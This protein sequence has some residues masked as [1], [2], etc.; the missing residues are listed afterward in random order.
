MFN[1]TDKFKT[2]KAD[3]S[4]IFIVMIW[5]TTFPLMKITLGNIKPFYFISLRFITA[6]IV[7]TLILNKRILK[8]NFKTFKIGVFLGLLLFSGFAFQIYGLQFTTASKSGFITGLSVLIVPILSIFILKEIPSLYAWVG[9]FLALIGIYLLTG[10]T[11]M[12]FN[13]GDLLTFFCAVSIALQIVFLSKYIKKEDPLIITWLQISTVMVVGTIL[14]FFESSSGQ[15]NL[16]SIGVIIYT[17]V[18]ATAIAI[19]VQSRAQ[20]FTSSTH[21]G[22]IF[23]LEPVFAALFSF[24]ILDERMQL[25]GIL[26]G[27]LIFTGIVLSELKNKDLGEKDVKKQSG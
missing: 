18:F 23:S 21:T 19:F 10:F 7:L 26:G 6:F 8:L 25:A 12:G 24:L 15:V 1:D 17:G 3:L 14:S 16:N 4:L 22:L 2:V 20:Q 13:I 9:V 11:E 5:G 27:I